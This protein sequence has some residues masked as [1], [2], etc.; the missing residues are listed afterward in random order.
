MSTTQ[1]RSN[2]KISHLARLY[3]PRSVLKSWC[4]C[5]LIQMIQLPHF[6]R[7]R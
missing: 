3:V 7:V 5:Q 2:L 4:P 6:S 1:T